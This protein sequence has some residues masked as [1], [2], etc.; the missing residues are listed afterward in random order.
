MEIFFCAGDF[1]LKEKDR[2]LMMKYIIKQNI[3]F[4]G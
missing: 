3:N 1:P 4:S 2:N